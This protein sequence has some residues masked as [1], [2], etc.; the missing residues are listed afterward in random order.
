MRPL[1]LGTFADLEGEGIRLTSLSGKAAPEVWARLFIF[2]AGLEGDD[3]DE[4]QVLALLLQDPIALKQFQTELAHSLES[5]STA[6]R[7]ATQRKV[8]DPRNLKKKETQ[9]E[10]PADEEPEELDASFVLMVARLSG[11]SLADISRMSF[12]GVLL[13]QEWL[14]ENPPQPSL[15][16]LFG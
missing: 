13:L 6:S 4:D 1:S 3:A 5:K 11:L 16:G 14:K 2:L 12:A 10:E 9:R 15:G 7:T 8:K